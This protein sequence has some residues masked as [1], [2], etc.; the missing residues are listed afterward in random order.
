VPDSYRGETVAAFVVL[1]DGNQPTE[2]TRQSI[3]QLCKEK[4]TAYKVPKKLEFRA[5]L[6]KTL[7]GKVLRRALR[8]E[9]S[10]S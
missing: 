8:E 3:L 5:E 10:A 9:N 6:P 2:E 7:V 4:L 1:K